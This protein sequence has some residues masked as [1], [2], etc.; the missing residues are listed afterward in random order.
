MQY[1]PNE[2]SFNNSSIQPIFN[3]LETN[4]KKKKYNTQ[5]NATKVKINQKT[6]RRGDVNL[7][8]TFGC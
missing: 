1:E 7:V 4:K 6:S 2:C 8:H 5:L 3:P